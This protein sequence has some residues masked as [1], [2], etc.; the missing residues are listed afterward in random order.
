MGLLLSCLLRFFI[1]I[2]INL[3]AVNSAFSQD[4]DSSKVTLIK[5]ITIY[6]LKFQEFSRGSYQQKLDSALEVLPAR[7]LSNLLQRNTSVYIRN[8]GNQMLSTISIRGTGSGHTATLWNGLNI[9][10]PTL[11]QFD[12]SQAPSIVADELLIHYGGSSALFGNESIGGSVVMQS[13]SEWRN[14]PSVL[15]YQ[16]VGSFGSLNS[17]AT[18]RVNSNY[19]ESATKAYLSKIENNFPYQNILLPGT[20][21]EQQKNARSK[22]NGLVQDLYWRPESGKEASVHAWLH[23]SN[24]QLQPSMANPDSEDSQEDFNIRVQAAWKQSGKAGYINT[25]LGFVHDMMTYNQSIKTGSNQTVLQSEIGK[26]FGNNLAANIGGSLQ[27]INV[28]TDNYSQQ[29]H[30][31]RWDIYSW[32]RFSPSESWSTTAN[33]RFAGTSSFS[34]PFSPSLGSELVLLTTRNGKLTW[35]SV[36]SINYRIP[37]LNDRYWNPGGNPTLIPENSLSI[38][39]GFEYSHKSS[40]LSYN[41]TMRF[42]SMSVDNWI[43]WLPDNIIW[44]P[45]NIR[46]VHNSGLELNVSGNLKISNGH[47]F[48]NSAYSYTKATNLTQIDQYDRSINKQLPYVPYHQLTFSIGLK[49][50]SWETS[51]TSSYTGDRFTSTDNQDKLESFGLIDFR[52]GKSVEKI[53]VDLSIDNLFDTTYYHLPYRAMPGRNYRMG[54]SLKI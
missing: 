28:E 3:I 25:R 50:S 49:R 12:F 38:E 42:Y 18:F 44:R 46:H 9:G 53:M 24:R 43:I 23:G 35:E 33:L 13:Q 54:I 47:L 20:P 32:V 52:I 26:S 2:G 31:N 51:I 29:V 37:T 27:H 10:S 30:E 15:V 48:W 36:A 41:A 6:G 11:G 39:S 45:Q 19:F 34:S 14:K 4:S 40:F 22:Q 1:L 5:G 8:Y 16:D 17:M 21:V 7:S